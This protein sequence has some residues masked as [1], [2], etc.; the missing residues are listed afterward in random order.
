MKWIKNIS[1]IAIGLAVLLL[2]QLLS[3]SSSMVTMTQ[4][5]LVNTF[6]Y[7]N[8][9]VVDVNITIDE[10]IYDEMIANAMSEEMVMA[11]VTYNGTTLESIGIRPKGNSSLQQV[12][13][14]GDNRFSFKVDLNEYIEGQNIYGL[15]KFNLNNLFEDPSM[16]AEYLSYEMLDY[17]GADTPRTAFISLSIND[18]YYG[19]YLAVEHVDENFLI[20]HFGNADGVL[21]KPDMEEGADLVYSETE[22][23]AGLIDQQ[24]NIDS[25]EE[26]NELMKRISEDQPIDDIFNVD[27][28]L[29]YLAVSSMVI[30]YDSYQ[31]AMYHNY[32]LFENEG[33]WEWIGWDFNMAF[34]G[35]P[36]SSMTNDEAILNYIDEP[37]LGSME[38]YPL[39]EAILS[40][41]ENIEKY[42]AY[43]QELIDGYLEED[44][45]TNRV[46]T[47]KSLIDS[48]VK[49]DSSKFFS[50]EEFLE[51]VSGESGIITFM[52]N[53]VKNVEEQLSG[54]LPSTNDGNG[55]EGSSNSNNMQGGRPEGD[56][57]EGG[58]STIDVDLLIEVVGENQIP[59]S[60]LNALL[61]DE[62]PE[63]EE[64]KTFMDLLSDDEKEQLM[65]NAQQPN[66]EMSGPSG[67]G[68]ST[69]I[70]AVKEIVQR[71]SLSIAIVFGLIVFALGLIVMKLRR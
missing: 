48:Y 39:V 47:I 33:M 69:N 2:F 49:T 36:Q 67:Q 65:V 13:K 22:M 59:D 15:E 9:E 28:F 35:F 26:I 34:N 53:R 10:D 30:H 45:F 31:G 19:L 55:N 68:N 18:V 14:S 5:D 16:M 44:L 7:P 50:Y 12:F 37:V 17:L 64:M 61:N 1:V 8:D 71:D 21:Y 57:P 3:G 32:Y 63:P 41:D 70:S 29:K 20:D 38:S 58:M 51:G 25:T 52:S 11:S 4:D 54:E 24:E 42:H 40:D 56:R 27:S 60:I 62:E 46:L 6:V 43:I 66:G 23:Y